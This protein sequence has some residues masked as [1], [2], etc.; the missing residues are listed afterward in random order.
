M[1]VLGD[2][3][4]YDR[5]VRTEHPMCLEIPGDPPT[6]YTFDRFARMARKTGNFLARHGLGPERPLGLVDDTASVPVLGLYAAGLL[7]APVVVEPPNLEDVAC[8]LGPMASFETVD[9]PAGTEAVGYGG[10]DWD[11]RLTAF[12]ETV[13]RENPGFP[14]TSIDPSAAL[15]RSGGRTFSHEAVL[16]TANRVRSEHALDP[17]DRVSVWAPLADPGTIV[18]GLVAPVLA[19]ATIILTGE[20]TEGDVIVTHETIDGHHIDPHQYRPDA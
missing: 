19:D 10:E 6:R 11:P 7:G 1:D 13:P 8:V 20:R 14:P 15:I 3:V 16:E 17:G 2:L 9:V 4:A 12:E 5:S 18:A